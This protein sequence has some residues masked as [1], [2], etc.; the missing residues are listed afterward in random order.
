MQP[1]QYL[2]IYP[3][4]EKQDYLLF[5][6][7]KK[8]SKILLKRETFQSIE[9]DTLSP[10]DGAVL[11][12]LGMIVDDRQAE[13]RAMLSFMDKLNA[14][15]TGLSLM[16]VLNLDCNFACTYCYEG[17]MK[18]KH[19]MST[20]VADRLIDFIKERFTDDKKSLIIDFYGGEPLL[21]AGLIKR[22]SQGLKSFTEA[23]GATY[24]FTLVTN[25]SFFARQVA[26]ALVPLGLK[27]VKITLDGPPEIHDKCRPFKSGAGSFNT[28]IKNIKETWDLV[29]IGIGGNFE[30]TNYEKFVL[31]LDY[32]A[33]EG[34]TPDKIPMVKFDPVMNGA[35]DDTLPAVYKGGC[36]SINEPWIGEAA[37]FLR[38]E[39]LKRGYNTLKIMPITCMVEKADSY[40]VNFDGVIYKCPG[41]IGQK[42]F[43]VGDVRTGVRDYASSYKLGIW[44]NEE[45]IECEYLP[46]C[47]GGC[48]YMSFIRDGYIDTVDCQKAYLDASLETLI[49]QDIR[50]SLKADSR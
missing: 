34:L 12:K 1:S 3:S 4:E 13:R 28:I 9:K 31:L 21:S 14:K 19:Y 36:T 37:A 8:A 24:E 48:R 15:S 27:S 33:K 30:R 7:T 2:K 29:K 46:L 38:E 45:C 23:K 43:E 18:G 44:K 25:G 42:G 11:S 49:N 26:E 35:K 16:V 22:I 5:F 40:V 32:L 47:F 50:Y 41:F 39:I 17:D 20:D 10:S 6:S